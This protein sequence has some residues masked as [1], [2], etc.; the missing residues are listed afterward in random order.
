MHNEN[1]EHHLWW[2]AI[3]CT[4]ISAV[5]V[6][7]RILLRSSDVRCNQ[8]VGLHK[9]T[10]TLFLSVSPR[11]CLSVCLPACL[12]ICLSLFPSPTPSFS[13][14][15]LFLPFSACKR[16]FDGFQAIIWKSTKASNRATQ[17]NHK[18]PAKSRKNGQRALQIRRKLYALVLAEYWRRP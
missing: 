15:V 16:D 9:H 7:K 13:Q 2:P 8:D 3:E 1:D 11:V 5:S 10:H 14:S 18:E 6:I 17:R 4:K 12:S